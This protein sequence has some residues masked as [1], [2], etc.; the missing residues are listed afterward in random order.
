VAQLAAAGGEREHDRGRDGQD[1]GQYVHAGSRRS[2][3]R[4]GR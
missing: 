2:V 3:Q 1:E 4:S